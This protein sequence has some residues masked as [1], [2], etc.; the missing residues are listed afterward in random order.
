MT[1]AV[2]SGDPPLVVAR[3]LTHSQAL[4]QAHV[5]VRNGHQDVRIL[6]ERALLTPPASPNAPASVVMTS[7]N[8]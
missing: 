3:G 5:L 1:Y 4:G 6:N 8:S 2:T 7:R